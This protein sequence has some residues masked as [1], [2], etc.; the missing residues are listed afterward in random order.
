MSL[1]SAYRR[2]EDVR[3]GAV[4]VAELKLRDV[5]RHCFRLILRRVRLFRRLEFN[6][7]Y[8]PKKTHRV[9]TGLDP[10]VH[11]DIRRMRRHGKTERAGSLHG[12]PDQVRQ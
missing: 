11:G 3:I 8:R 12:L 4:V 5:E 9:T 2:A 7:E 10:V 1:T 6:V